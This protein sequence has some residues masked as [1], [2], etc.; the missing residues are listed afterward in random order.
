MVDLKQFEK[1]YEWDE[2]RSTFMR[3][4]ND[5]DLVY[6]IVVGDDMYIDGTRDLNLVTSYHLKMLLVKAHPNKLMQ[7]AFDREK[8]LSVYILEHMNAFDRYERFV[9][10]CVEKYNP[11]LNKCGKNVTVDRSKW[12]NVDS[13]FSL[14]V[15]FDE[16]IENQ[17][18]KIQDKQG[19]TMHELAKTAVEYFLWMHECYKSPLLSN[20]GVMAVQAFMLGDVADFSM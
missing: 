17:L 18:K 6:A 5:G 20:E 13:S 4:V 1:V 11:S 14:Q 9:S 10:R 7:E 19:V 15:S 16:K 8:M 12:K 3:V 2:F